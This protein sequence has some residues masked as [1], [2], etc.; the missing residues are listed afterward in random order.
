MTRGAGVPGGVCLTA[1]A[2]HGS[3]ASRRPSHSDPGQG[4]PG[5]EQ[6]LALS[7]PSRGDRWGWR[8]LLTRG[9]VAAHAAVRSIAAPTTHQPEP[10]W[11][12]ARKSLSQVSVWG[13]TI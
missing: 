2:D 4:A 10:G 1:T 9:C 7:P 13:C 8:R 6:L 5:R 11:D 3:A 12:R